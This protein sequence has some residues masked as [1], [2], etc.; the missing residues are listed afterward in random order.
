MR[1]GCAGKRALFNVILLLIGAVLLA[2]PAHGQ[3][4]AAPQ[5]TQTEGV[6]FLPAQELSPLFLGMYR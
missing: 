3:P 2:A 6:A 5:D 4:Y 1:D